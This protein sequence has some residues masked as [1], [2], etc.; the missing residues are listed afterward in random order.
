MR[1]TAAFT[2]A[3]AVL[4]VSLTAAMASAQRQSDDGVWTL[5]EGLP[6][7][8]ERQEPWIRPVFFQPLSMDRELARQILAD[9]PM[10]FTQKGFEEPLLIQLPDPDG[11]LQWFE[12]VESPMMEPELAAKF[13]EIKTY[14]G[15]GVDD[16]AA[17]VRLNLS[18]A[19]FHAQVLT[20]GGAWLID[21]Y[22]RND[23]VVHTSYWRSDYAMGADHAWT[24]FGPIEVEPR[25]QLRSKDDR[26]ATGATLRQYRVAVATTGEY[27]A[28]HGGT[29][30]AGLAAVV[31]AMNRVNGLYERDVAVRM[32]LIAN[33]NLIIYTNAAT[34]P[35]TNNNGGTMLNQNINNLSATIG[36]A[37]FDI[38]HVFS[39]GGGGV[40]FLGVVCTSSKAGGVT[41]QPAPTGDVFWVDYVAHE[42]GHQFGANHTFNSSCGGNRSAS[43]AFEPGSGSTILAYAGVCGTNNIQFVSD[44]HF[45]SRSIEAI[46]A[47]IS[48][49]SGSACSAN[50]ATGNAIPVVDAGP[51]Y[52][53]PHNTPFELTAVASDA[54]PG[55]VLTYCWE[56]RDLGAAQNAPF[57]DNGTSPFIRSFPA[58]VSPTRTIPRPLNLVN[59]TFAVGET[60]PQTNRIVNFM[61][62]VRDNRAGAGATNSDTMQVTST[63][64]AGPFIVTSPNTAVSWS[65]QQTVTW[66]VAN[67]NAAPVN[68]ANVKIELSTDGGFTYPH[69][70]ASSVPN[71][72]SALV[73]L[74]AISTSQA[75]IK[76][77]GVGNIFFDISNANFT[78]TP[79]PAPSAFSLAGPANGASDVELEPMLSWTASSNADSYTVEIDTD[80]GFSMPFVYSTVV[81]APG[82]STAVPPGTLDFDTQYYWRVRAMNGS[83]NT[84][85]SPNPASFTTEADPFCP[86]D[87][88]GD[89]VVDFNDITSVLANWLSD[90]TPGT[91]PG[92]ANGDG[93]VD[94]NDIT[95]I[96]ANWLSN[97]P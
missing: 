57:T 97:C 27:T 14:A 52:T 30:P 89:N 42:M 51:N 4:V 36:N 3:V 38:G 81:A 28:F 16:P 18:H 88:N 26:V 71:T 94:F 48:S 17:T 91:G 84:T 82:L 86:G 92:D 1:F 54:D 70:L 79:P 33:N 15:R 56:Q 24:C 67:T 11:N 55:D 37:N 64:S 46:A 73:T 25:I 66:N 13:P 29:V 95:T 39:T 20:P 87:A 58:L 32:N 63:T 40:A 5:L 43:S 9:A 50:S 75:R 80:A 41:G 59:N 62:T 44:D 85:A 34:D 72:G 10:E 78:V 93:L 31:T 8:A 83:G 69:L 77:S 74:P 6:A 35:Y 21:P 22:T 49:G 76:V 90:Y 47:F 68:C 45:H 96:L 53:I 23:T 12:L 65:G 60:L 2:T 61:V 19:G 7:A